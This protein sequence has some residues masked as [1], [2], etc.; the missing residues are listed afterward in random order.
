MTEA[1]VWDDVVDVAFDAHVK[2]TYSVGVYT[3]NTGYLFE[4][5]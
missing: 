4:I 3:D 5:I 1:V 2:Q